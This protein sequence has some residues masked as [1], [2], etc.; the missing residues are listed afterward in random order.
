MSIKSISSSCVF[1]DQK[2]KLNILIKLTYF[3][4]YRM[5]LQNLLYRRKYNTIYKNKI[6]I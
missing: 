4:S 5:H 1:V 6:V 2:C 3:P